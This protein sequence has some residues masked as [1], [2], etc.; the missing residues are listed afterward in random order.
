MSN[1]KTSNVEL[2]EDNGWLQFTLFRSPKNNNINFVKNNILNI[3]KR[4]KYAIAEV[5]LGDKIDDYILEYFNDRNIDIHKSAFLSMIEIVKSYGIK[6]IVLQPS[7][8]YLISYYLSIGYQ[9][10]IIPY[11][12]YSENDYKMDCKYNKTCVPMNLIMYKKLE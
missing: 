2:Q 8:N 7:K 9:T 12:E 5:K 11:F 3:E 1:N 4:R 6:Y 10:D